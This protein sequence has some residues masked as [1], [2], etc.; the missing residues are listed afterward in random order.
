MTVVANTQSLY[1]P[2]SSELGIL[3]IIHLDRLYITIQLI[4]DNTASQDMRYKI[5]ITIPNI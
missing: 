3:Y 4:T 2:W 1:L 5:K